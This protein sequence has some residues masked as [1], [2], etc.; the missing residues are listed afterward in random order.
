MDGGVHLVAER[1]N[2]PG[3]TAAEVGVHLRS[4]E[5]LDLRRSLR[6]RERQQCGNKECEAESQK[7]R[8]RP[9]SPCP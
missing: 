3:E 7:A 9:G 2:K 4:D 5:L 1:K 6:R 8:A